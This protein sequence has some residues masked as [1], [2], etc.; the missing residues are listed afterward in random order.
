[1]FIYHLPKRLEFICVLQ[2]LISQLAKSRFL[3]VYLNPK[4][5]TAHLRKILEE[6]ILKRT[7]SRLPSHLGDS[8]MQVVVGGSSDDN[9]REK[10]EECEFDLSTQLKKLQ[11]FLCKQLVIEYFASVNVERRNDKDV[12]TGEAM[13]DDSQY[14]QLKPCVE[15][16][17]AKSILQLLPSC[18]FCHLTDHRLLANCKLKEMVCSFFTCLLT[19]EMLCFFIG[20]SVLHSSFHLLFQI[21]CFKCF[22]YGHSKKYCF[23]TEIRP[24]ELIF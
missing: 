7:I 18:P 17:P 5:A 4:T 23:K 10:E 9:K 2:K 22:D 11:D 3:L 20:M 1:M 12:R 24:E 19:F 8:F 16:P 21:I 14:R 6:S 13:V 15:Y